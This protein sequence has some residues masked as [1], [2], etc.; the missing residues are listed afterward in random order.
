[1]VG[2]SI[3][4]LVVNG[5]LEMVRV[6]LF[7]FA[8]EE[9]VLVSQKPASSPDWTPPIVDSATFYVSLPSTSKLKEDILGTIQLQNLPGER[10][11]LRFLG[12]VK[13]VLPAEDK[14]AHFSTFCSRFIDHLTQLGFV[15]QKEE[16]EGDL[17]AK[18]AVPIPSRS[19]RHHLFKE[20]RLDPD[21]NLCFVIMPFGDPFDGIYE[22]SIE[23]TVIRLGLRC[24]RADRISERGVIMDQVWAHIVRARVIIAELTE[25]NPNV[26]YELGL[27]H[28]LDKPVI[29]L[30]QN[31]DDVPFD[32]RHTRCIIYSNTVPGARE[33]ERVLSEA[34]KA[35]LSEPYS[36]FLPE[37][38]KPSEETIQYH[39]EPF[40]LARA[41]DGGEWF[42]G[43]INR[44][45][46]PMGR[47]RLGDV[48]FD[49]DV[50]EHPQSH[51]LLPRG[52]SVS[53]GPGNTPAT[54]SIDHISLQHV[55]AVFLLLT[56]GNG[57]RRDQKTGIP[58]QGKAIG[59]VTL[60]F[61]NGE[62]QV[63]NLILG[64]NIREWHLGSEFDVV[65]ELGPNAGTTQVWT[66]RGNEATLD[67]LHISVERSLRPYKLKSI[68]I[69]AHLEEY[70]ANMVDI[71]VIQLL[72]VTCRML[73]AEQT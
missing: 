46:P 6:Q 36:I 68:E 8:Q 24:V 45:I 59:K 1:M 28:A 65:R 18:R 27:A 58:L 39:D 49:V 4:D 22:S 3:R 64:Y 38:K 35:V 63:V 14:R 32:L 40:A 23:Q 21:P 53:P 17:P 33:L 72:G 30:A 67:M 9:N 51:E 16:H 62:S 66:T 15:L 43:R 26:F 69:E 52:K 47:V 25:Q 7:D 73:G 56:A 44:Q 34:I 71:P 60:H 70:D 50:G 48:L 55:N 29:Q 61:E 41:R 11:L 37:T 57:H 54:I 19:L 20:T 5:T 10:T 2:N 42:Y 12:T 31:I 13:G